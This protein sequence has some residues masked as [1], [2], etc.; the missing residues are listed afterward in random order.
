MLRLLFTLFCFISSLHAEIDISKF[1]LQSQQALN[2]AQYHPD[3]ARQM[4]EKLALELEAHLH[5]MDAPPAH[6]CY[7]LGNLWYH[8]G[9]LGKSILWY[10]RAELQI[11]Y[12]KMLLHNLAIVK[13]ERL[14]ELPDSFLPS[15]FVYGDTLSKAEPIFFGAWLISFALLCWT[16]GMEFKTGAKNQKLLLR[17]Y[18][19]LGIGLLWL[20]V[21]WI[22]SQK[23]QGIVIDS[24]VIARKGNGLIFA[25]AF[26]YP[27]HEGTEVL[28]LEERSG[29]IYVQLS[30]GQTCWLPQ[31][32]LAWI[33]NK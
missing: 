32:S 7:N 27:L 11:P 1:E 15:W 21:T 16:F 13:S 22:D 18:L 29:W 10:R 26:T 14:D 6:L 20:G 12:S 25:P 9:Q 24:E 28:K 2:M 3:K 30:N 31:Q 4:Q 5:K 17:I 33:E 19:C 23:G 8:A